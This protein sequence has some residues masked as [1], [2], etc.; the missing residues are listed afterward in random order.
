MAEG[1]AGIQGIPEATAQA[2]VVNASAAKNE[3]RF[4]VVQNNEVLVEAKSAENQKIS[5]ITALIAEETSKYPLIEENDKSSALDAGDALAPTVENNI[6]I[7]VTTQAENSEG[8]I[9]IGLKKDLNDYMGGKGTSLKD[10]SHVVKQ[11]DQSEVINL[12][13]KITKLFKPQK[14]KEPEGLGLEVYIVKDD[15]LNELN[16]SDMRRDMQTETKALKTNEEVNKFEQSIKVKAESMCGRYEQGIINGELKGVILF[17]ESAASE[18]GIIHEIMHSK[19][20]LH[21]DSGNNLNEATTQILTLHTQ[22][23]NLDVV[24][25]YDKIVS[26]EI[27]SVGYPDLVVQMLSIMKYT[28]ENNPFTIEDLAKY[29][30]HD[31]SAKEH[32]L[33]ESMIEEIASKTRKGLGENAKTYLSNDLRG[34]W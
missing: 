29:Y 12:E 14:T 1:G 17:K 4:S 6:V 13:D 19:G 8:N 9:T 18:Q 5:E 16:A 32:V 26:G 33:A 15:S 11:I 2:A 24:N 30:F 22:Y 27:I 20:G 7:E 10:S 34:A 3:K 31:N 28:D 23:P 25:L 21:S